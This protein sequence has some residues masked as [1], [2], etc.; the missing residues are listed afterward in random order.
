MHP[1]AHRHSAGAAEELL[2]LPSNG[3][4]FHSREAIL[5]AEGAHV[6]VQIERAAARAYGT[7]V[8][9]IPM[10]GFGTKDVLTADLDSPDLSSTEDYVM[11]LSARADN[12]C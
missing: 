1:T 12:L 5:I 10:K 4:I 3:V 7:R 9:S 8:K 2:T 11:G 6:G